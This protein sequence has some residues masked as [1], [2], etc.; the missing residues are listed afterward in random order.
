MIGGADTEGSKSDIA[1]NIWP[2]QTR[3]PCDNFSDTSWL[4]PKKPEG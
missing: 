1:M 2:L 4:K 3:Y